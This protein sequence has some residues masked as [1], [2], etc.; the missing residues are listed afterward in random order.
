MKTRWDFE[1]LHNQ[2]EKA[3]QIVLQDSKSKSVSWSLFKLKEFLMS[4][5][6]IWLEGTAI[7]R[8]HQSVL[9]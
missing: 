6:I 8:S 1:T 5:I 9:I 4:S 2:L 7:Q 3:H